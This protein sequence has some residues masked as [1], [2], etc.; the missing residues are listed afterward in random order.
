MSTFTAS[1]EGGVLRP[2][3]PLDL[4]EH[5]KVRVTIE[6]LPSSRLTVAGLSSF[7]KRLPPLGDDSE[8]F[9]KDVRAVRDAF[10]AE[11]S[12]WD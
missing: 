3:Q 11:P 9:E 10:P 8:Q 7:L 1:F 5:T 4:P 2:L 6:P 12:K